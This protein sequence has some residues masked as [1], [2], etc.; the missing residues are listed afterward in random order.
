MSDGD[1]EN[2]TKILEQDSALPPE[3]RIKFQDN[4]NAGRSE[5][6]PSCAIDVY[7]DIQFFDLRLVFILI[8]MIFV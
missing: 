4:Q 3:K 6:S 5:M 7:P 8:R 1:S 2:I